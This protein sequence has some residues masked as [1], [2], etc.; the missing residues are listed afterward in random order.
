MVADAALVPVRFAP[1]LVVAL[2][3]GTATQPLLPAKLGSKQCCVLKSTEFLARFCGAGVIFS[4]GQLFRAVQYAG[5][6][7]SQLR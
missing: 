3:L 6:G 7:M 4:A 1:G 5:T 2:L